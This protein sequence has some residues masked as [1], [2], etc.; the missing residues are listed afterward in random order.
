MTTPSNIDKDEPFLP[1]ADLGVMKVQ[2][3]TDSSYNRTNL[4]KIKVYYGRK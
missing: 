1:T 4:E 2:N 3:P